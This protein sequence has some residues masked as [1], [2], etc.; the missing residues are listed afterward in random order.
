[1]FDIIML[2]IIKG[3]MNITEV[4]RRD[5]IDAIM[6]EEVNWA[7]RLDEIEFLS[8]LFD[9]SALP[10]KDSRYENAKD[11]IWQ[12][13]VNNL[14]EEDDWIFYDERFN[15]LETEDEIFLRFLCKTIDPVVR[16]DV[17]EAKMLCKMYNKYLKKV[18][19]ELF[20][21]ERLSGKPVF[22]WREVGL[23]DAPGISAAKES[24]RARD[25]NYVNQQIHRMEAAVNS[26]PESAIGTSKELIETCCKT[27]LEERNIDFPKNSD[28]SQL[29]KLTCK[30]LKLT[31]DD[32]KDTAKAA[33][34]IKRLLNNLAS[35]S[36]GIAELRNKYGTGHGKS[37]KTKGLSP[38]HAKLAVGAASTLAVFL[39]ETHKEKRN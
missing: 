36:K 9:L 38:R 12:H 21:K 17:N 31:P 14:D 4:T 37:A 10:S 19:Y 33:D 13:R 25:L 5:I 23:I 26:D 6:N 28:I 8:R 32:I 3:K 11:D 34:I 16:S 1:M 30:E 18:G 29:V 20:E 2:G 35:I 39:M 27:I 7:G 24:F 22:A 15:L